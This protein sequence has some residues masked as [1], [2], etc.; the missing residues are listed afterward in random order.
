LFSQSDESKRAEKTLELA[1]HKKEQK[2]WIY[3]W[4][5]FIYNHL[6]MDGN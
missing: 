4:A 1:I 5:R 3:T 6:D 2:S